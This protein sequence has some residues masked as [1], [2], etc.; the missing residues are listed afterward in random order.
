MGQGLKCEV[1]MKMTYNE[2]VE[3]WKNKNIH[4]TEDLKQSLSSYKIIFAYNSG[5]IENEEITYHNTR[6]IF[7]NGKVVNFSGNLRTIYEIENQKKCF[8][9]LIEKIIEK[10][11]ITES[12]ILDIHKK[13][14]QGT[15]DEE[16]WKKGE[17]SGKFKVNDY[18]VADEQGA[19]PEE[20]PGEIAELCEELCDI[21][22]RGENIIRAAAYL[23]C[24]FEN[25]HPFADGNGRVGRTLM[26][27]FLMTHNYPPLV[28]YNDTKDK[29]YEALGHYDKTG[30]VI[31]FTQYM[32]ESLEKTWERKAV[33]EQKLNSMLQETSEENE[34][35]QGKVSMERKQEILQE[36]KGI[37][38]VE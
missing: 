18:C 20:V 29:Y 6:E 1:G 34:I 32:K 25:I 30:D 37:N 12:L 24:K 2:I 10:E 7:E 36:M 27:Y 4:T 22:D 26:N 15:Y 8:D 9:F 3:R 16:R 13:L 17:R 38:L 28:V 23:H 33:P 35:Q 5:V 11:S 14:T 31:P 19:L 21:P